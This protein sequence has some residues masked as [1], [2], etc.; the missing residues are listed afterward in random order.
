MSVSRSL[1]TPGPRTIAP[2]AVELNVTGPNLPVP[3]DI[4]PSLQILVSYEEGEVHKRNIHQYRAE[5]FSF[6]RAIFL[7]IS[8]LPD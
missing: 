2:S 5:P 4:V 8:G 3:V 1:C 7:R 6:E